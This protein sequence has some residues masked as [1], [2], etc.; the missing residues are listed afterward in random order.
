MG[1][2]S[3]GLEGTNESQNPGQKAKPC[4]NEQEKNH[5]VGFLFPVELA[6]DFALDLGPCLGSYFGSC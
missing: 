4:T 3:L 2:I 1:Q 6:L 5:V